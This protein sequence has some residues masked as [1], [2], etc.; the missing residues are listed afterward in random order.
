MGDPF[1]AGLSPRRK[2]TGAWGGGDMEPKG[3]RSITAEVME[4]KVLAAAILEAA[5]SPGGQRRTFIGFQREEL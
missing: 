2:S 5:F 1:H 3:R 4:E